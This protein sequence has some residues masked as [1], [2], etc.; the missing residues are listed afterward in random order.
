[1]TGVTLDELIEFQN[2]NKVNLPCNAII[3]AIT[4]G[5]IVSCA[6]HVSIVIFFTGFGAPGVAVFQQIFKLDSTLFSTSIQ[7][8]AK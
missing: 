1:M 8:E 6:T 3:R 2:R 5:G 7:L 4:V